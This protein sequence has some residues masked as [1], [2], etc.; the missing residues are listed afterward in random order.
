MPLTT[1]TRNRHVFVFYLNIHVLFHHRFIHVAR[2][3]A[4]I[5]QSVYLCCILILIPKER[6]LILRQQTAA[7]CIQQETNTCSTII[8]M[9]LTTTTKNRHVFVFYLNIPLL[10]HHRFIHMQH[11]NLQKFISLYTYAVYLYLY[12]RKD[13]LY[14]DNKQPMGRH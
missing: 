4:E 2:K 12:L 3:L 6:S 1:T 13:R 14:L 5:H 9:P 7:S 11:V 8:V 10:F